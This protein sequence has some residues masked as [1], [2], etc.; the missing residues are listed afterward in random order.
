[1]AAVLTCRAF[2]WYARPSDALFLLLSGEVA[3]HQGGESEL[4]L[5]EGAFFGESSL[6]Y[7]H[8]DAHAV[9]QANVV[10]VSAVR[11]ARLPASYIEAILGP[12]QHALDRGFVEK[13]RN[14]RVAP[15]IH[16]LRPPSLTHR[17]RAWIRREG[18]LLH[19]S[20]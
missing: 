11:V 3:C 17:L 15:S 2:G 12:L 10:A 14:L 1:M 13:V 7:V 16:D 5:A 20:L 9:R 6:Q 18:R 19:C 8:A 4:R